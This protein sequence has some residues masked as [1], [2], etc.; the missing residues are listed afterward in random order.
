MGMPIRMDTT[1]ENAMAVKVWS[2]PVTCATF[3]QL[4]PRNNSSR[5]R[6]SRALV[7]ALAIRPGDSPD[8]HGQGRVQQGS[9]TRIH[10]D[11]STKSQRHHAQD[12]T[13][14]AFVGRQTFVKNGSNIRSRNARPQRPDATNR[15]TFR[16][17]APRTQAT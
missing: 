12:D 4:K 15:K 7:T 6:P 9:S 5:R 8:Q 11:K 13:Q 10:F 2:H 14:Y 17:F 1:S 3:Y 16:R